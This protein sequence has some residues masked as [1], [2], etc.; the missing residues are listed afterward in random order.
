MKL[1]VNG[2]RSMIASAKPNGLD[3]KMQR[4]WAK[5]F[6]KFIQ[7]YKKHGIDMWAVTVQ[8]EPEA[9]VGWEACLWTPQYQAS[10][11]KDSVKRVLLSEFVD[12]GAT[13]LPKVF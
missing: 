5:Y 9:A 10:F 12:N 11:V 1:P 7:A 13:S 3:P 2:N 6:S 8:N 4:P